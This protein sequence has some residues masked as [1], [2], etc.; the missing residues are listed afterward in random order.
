MR[1]QGWKAWI[2]VMDGHNLFT[3]DRQGRWGGGEVTPSM[4]KQLRG[5]EIFYGEPGFW[6]R[7]VVGVRDDRHKSKQ[8]RSQLGRRKNFFVTRKVQHWSRL[9]RQAVQS[10]SSEV[11]KSKFVLEDKALRNLVWPS[12]QPLLWAGGWTTDLLRSLL[13]WMVLR[14]C[15][16]VWWL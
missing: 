4:K 1:S 3:K 16:L 14:F 2:T 11:F 12:E 7:R 8:E 15:W 6:Q 5:R 13:P 9:P 10:P